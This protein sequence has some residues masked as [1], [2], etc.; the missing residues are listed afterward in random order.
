MSVGSR[1]PAPDREGV[2]YLWGFD[3]DDREIIWYVGKTTN[4]KKRL[5]EHYFNLMSCQY[6]VPKGFLKGSFDSLADVTSGWACD[7][8][9]PR[10]VGKLKDW[11]QMQDVFKGGHAFAHR[12]FARVAPL[13]GLSRDELGPPN[14][15]QSTTCSRLSSSNVSRL[16]TACR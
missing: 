2:L 9:D 1:S 14:T 4:F 3:A 5:I 7:R 6:Q 13:A 11:A 16:L 8:W 10:V 15:R 12:A